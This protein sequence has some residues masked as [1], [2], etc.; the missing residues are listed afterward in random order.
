MKKRI[1]SLILWIALLTA[2][3]TPVFA[4]QDVPENVGSEETDLKLLSTIQLKD[5]TDEETFL[6]TPSGIPPAIPDSGFLVP[7]A[8]PLPTPGENGLMCDVGD[9]SGNATA[10]STVDEFLAIGTGGN[11]Y[12]DKDI[13]L[14]ALT[15][16]AGITLS[17]ALTLDGQGH[18]ISGL[19]CTLFNGKGPVTLRNW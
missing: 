11:Y 18:T 19:A 4:E 12:L 1:L 16:W 5:G 3:M 9:P 7:L 17:D 13:D 10:I 6:S 14:S 15:D 8:E 2:L